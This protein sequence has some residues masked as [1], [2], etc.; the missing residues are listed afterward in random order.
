MST[1]ELHALQ[2]QL[3]TSIAST[4]Q[5]ITSLDSVTKKEQK[6]LVSSIQTL[7][8]YIGILS[9]TNKEELD[10]VRQSI[11][12]LSRSL[13]QQL[14][15]LELKVDCAVQ[16]S[17]YSS[18]KLNED[19]YSAL[20]GDLSLEVLSHNNAAFGAQA[21][22]ATTTNVTLS[23]LQTIDT[24]SVVADDLVLVKDQ[25][26]K[27]EN[28]V[29]KAATGAWTRAPGLSV[30]AEIKSTYGLFVTE[31]SV[32]EHKHY[33]LQTESGTIDTTD[34]VFNEVLST[35]QNLLAADLNASSNYTRTL[36]VRLVDSTG[37]IQRWANFE[38]T[39]TPAETVVDADV[40]VP[41]VEYT[42]NP[43]A[44]P[45]FKN[46]SLLLTVKPDVDS[47]ATKTYAASDSID[48]TIDLSG[49]I[50]C[51]NVPNLQLTYPIL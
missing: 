46:G 15:S 29:Y 8:Q 30:D 16:S 12:S 50:L 35:S 21:R 19:F 3:T 20:S 37:K 32:N 36:E 26:T 22:C 11:L 7:G 6:E 14:A 17:N 27:S 41:V 28:G 24:V 49:N 51:A 25:T 38:P 9:L 5:H 43:A 45:K 44:N 40:G 33:V 4:M 42:P 34:L 10:F 47:G 2:E 1:S 13:R 23:G 39:I 18:T 31:G 48:F